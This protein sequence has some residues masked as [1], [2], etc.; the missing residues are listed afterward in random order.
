MQLLVEAES[1]SRRVARAADVV[2]E[3]EE[4]LETDAQRQHVDDVRHAKAASR[5]LT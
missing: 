1:P 4:R 5:D 2:G 3:E